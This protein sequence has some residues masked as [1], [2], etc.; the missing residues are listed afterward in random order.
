MKALTEHLLISGLAKEEQGEN[1][2]AMILFETDEDLIVLHCVN[3]RML[4]KQLTLDPNDFKVSE[5]AYG[6]ILIASKNLH[7]QILQALASSVYKVE[8]E[9]LDDNMV[10]VS[11]N[12]EEEG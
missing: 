9:L 6:M 7:L 10:N 5:C 4:L 11:H 12:L 1:Y 2:Y 8:G 3:L